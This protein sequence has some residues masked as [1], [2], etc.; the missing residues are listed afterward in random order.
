MATTGKP[1]NLAEMKTATEMQVRKEGAVFRP[2]SLITA[3]NEGT[4]ISLT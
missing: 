3:T 4:I 2:P 1:V